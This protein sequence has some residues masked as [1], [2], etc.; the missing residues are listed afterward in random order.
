MVSNDI[1]LGPD[2]Y[3]QTKRDGP[4]KKNIKSRRSN[5]DTIP[6]II[7]TAAAVTAAAIIFFIIIYIAGLSIPAFQNIGVWD[8]VT[9]DRWSP[10]NGHYGALPLITGTILVTA[11]SIIFAVPLGVGAAI[12]ISEIAS[13]KS[14]NILK[15]VCEVF[16]GIPSVVYGFFGLLVLCPLL[17][18]I[19]PEQLKYSTSWLAGS[20]LLGIMALPT[21]ISVSEDAI[22]AVPKSYRHSSLAM[23]ATGWENDH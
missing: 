4:E 13:E 5:P 7:I 15:P 8:F 16:A 23:G 22:R 14:R 6:K 12:Y 20:I 11:G 21:V 19:F 9:G 1:A 3:G 2:E 10:S 17:L 18:D